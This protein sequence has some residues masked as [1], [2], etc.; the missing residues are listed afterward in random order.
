PRRVGAERDPE[1]AAATRCPDDTAGLDRAA[2]IAGVD[3]DLAVVRRGGQPSVGRKVDAVALVT[4]IFVAGCL[5][6]AGLLCVNP[7]SRTATEQGGQARAVRREDEMGHNVR[8]VL[9]APHE[10]PGGALE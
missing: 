9:Y 8:Q 4:V 3:P 6:P 2:K 5:R 10:L 1:G 7:K